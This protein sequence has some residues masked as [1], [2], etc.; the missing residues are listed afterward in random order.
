MIAH[1]TR[2]VIE[3]R[4]HVSTGQLGIFL[5]HVFDG[6]AGGEEFQ[7]RLHR[8]AS[9]PDDGP[10]VANVRLDGNAF[11]HAVTVAQVGD[12]PKRKAG[13]INAFKV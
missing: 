5:Q 7:H 12:Y 8:D 10:P 11:R 3:A 2:G 9:A 4:L 6:V 13:Y 1:D